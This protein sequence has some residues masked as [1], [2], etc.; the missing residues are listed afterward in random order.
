[1][2]GRVYLHKGH[3]EGA[4]EEDLGVVPGGEGVL[5]AAEMILQLGTA[6]LEQVDHQPAV[7]IDYHWG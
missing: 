4:A 2:T 5:A 7:G 3:A 6:L 1:M